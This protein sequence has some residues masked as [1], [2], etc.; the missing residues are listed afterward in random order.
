[1]PPA[2]EQIEGPG[3]WERVKEQSLPATLGRYWA[4]QDVESNQLRKITAKGEDGKSELDREH[5]RRVAAKE[6]AD[7]ASL[8]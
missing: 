6:K 2:Q 4:A 8:M 3:F 5:D 1:M 7:P